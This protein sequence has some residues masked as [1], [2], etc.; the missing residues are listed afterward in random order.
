MLRDWA[1]SETPG[2]WTERLR[3]IHQAKQEFQARL[4]F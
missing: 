3:L 1:A 4:E 2:L